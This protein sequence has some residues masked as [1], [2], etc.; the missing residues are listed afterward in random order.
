MG[1]VFVHVGAPKTGTTYLQDVLWANRRALR[2]QGALYWGR[3]RHAHFRAAQDL[4][5]RFFHGHEDP[6]VRGSW[7]RLAAAARRWTGPTVLVSHE[8]LSTCS[9]EEA[10][11]A[12]ASLA[13]HDVH[14]VYTARD[15][16][17]Q[18]PAMWQESVKNGR[19]VPYHRYLQTLQAD[20]P[21]SVGRVFWRTQ[22]AVGVLDRWGAAVP[23]ERIHVL[24]VPP[25]GAGDDALWRRFCAVTGLDADVMDATAGRGGNVS[26]GLAEAEVLRRLNRRLKGELA[27]PEHERLL[28]RFLTRNVLTR[29]DS[30]RAR[31]PADDRAWV[32]ARSH[33]LVEGLRARGY[34][35]VGSLDEL[36]PDFSGEPDADP[37]PELDT[38]LDTAV[39]AL[40]VLLTGR[41]RPRPRAAAGRL[42]RVARTAATRPRRGQI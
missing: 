38:V 22:D 26:L 27:W 31:I 13:P 11:R 19:V 15:L 37:R 21:Q 2:R 33:H 14:V 29:Q 6:R 20:D 3:D 7:Q 17:R 1:R 18:I 25:H 30:V 34:D 35:V 10:S 12:V 32:L 9:A 5:G 8:V 39:E 16:S 24:T 41:A 36:V 40:A 23:P 4:R 28:K 42:R